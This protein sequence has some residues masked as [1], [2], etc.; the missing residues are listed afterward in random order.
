MALPA[1]SKTYCSERLVQP[2]TVLFANPRE[3]LPLLKARDAGQNNAGSHERALTT[4][5][6]EGSCNFRGDDG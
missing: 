5:T 1:R 2:T 4:A 3:K 6:H